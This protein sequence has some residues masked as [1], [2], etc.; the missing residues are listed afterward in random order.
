M[1]SPHVD[2]GVLLD[3]CFAKQKADSLR[4]GVSLWAATGSA[5]SREVSCFVFVGCYKSLFHATSEQTS[6]PQGITAIVVLH[7]TATALF[8]ITIVIRA[9]VAVASLTFRTR[10]ITVS[11]FILIFVILIVV[12]IIVIKV[13]EVIRLQS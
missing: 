9:I 5:G 7:W 6:N 4:R 2:M 8:I 13:I 3:F 12:I 1:L 10:A 11:L